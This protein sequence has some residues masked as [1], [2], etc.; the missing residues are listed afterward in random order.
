MESNSLKDSLDKEI[1]SISDYLGK[2]EAQIIADL[3]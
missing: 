2:I 3:K 1:D